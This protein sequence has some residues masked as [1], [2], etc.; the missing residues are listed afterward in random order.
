MMP[1]TTIHQRWSAALA[2]ALFAGSASAVRADLLYLNPSADTSLLENFPDNNFGGQAWFNSGTTQ[3]GP[4]NR[5]LVRFDPASQIP[6]GSI[7]NSVSL[8]LEVVRQPVDGDAPSTFELHRMLRDWGEGTGTGQPPMLGRLA[9]AGEANWSYPF[10][11]GAPWAAPG[12]LPGVDFADLGSGDTYVYGTGLSPY[13]W[14]S[15]PE[16]IADLQLWVDQPSQNFGW[17]LISRSEAERFSARR[18][19]SREDGLRSPILTIDFT[20]VPEPTLL[21]LASLTFGALLLRRRSR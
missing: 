18:F 20:P 8:Q 1:S 19:G 16:M 14:D 15:T 3:N 10:A 4:R 5:G 11:G 12:G 2:A 21:A 13:T 6:A 9:L 17:M 7:I